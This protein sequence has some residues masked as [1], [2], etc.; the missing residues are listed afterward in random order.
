MIFVGLVARSR[1]IPRHNDSKFTLGYLR[2]T[3]HFAV[4]MINYDAYET[5]TFRII[6]IGETATPTRH[7]QSNYRVRLRVAP[8]VHDSG[9]RKTVGFP[10]AVRGAVRVVAV[11][12]S[13][14]V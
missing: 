5:S 9:G 7:S 6:E 4:R 3:R 2:Y 12:P 11:C 8:G 1:Q 10:Y 14:L 13:L